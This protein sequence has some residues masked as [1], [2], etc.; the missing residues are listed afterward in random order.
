MQSEDQAKAS[1]G[2]RTALADPGF[3]KNVWYVAGWSSEFDGSGPFARRIADEP[4]AFFRDAQGTLVALADRCPHRWA[5]L[6]LGRVE[7][8]T[9]RCMYHGL[10]FA[11]SGQCVEVPEQD[12]IAPGL[13][14]RSYPVVERHRFAWVW[15]GDAARADPALIPVLT[16]LD[17]ADWRIDSGQID[18]QANCALINDN[19]VDLSH[20]SFVHEK[21]FGQVPAALRGARAK[22]IDRGVRMEGW[23]AGDG[24]GERLREQSSGDYS[25]LDFWGRLDYVVPGIFHSCNDPYPGGTAKASGGE[26]PDA[27]T[28]PLAQIHSIQAVTPLGPR[29]SRYFFAF[30][31]S[32][33]VYDDAAA[34]AQWR[35]IIEA[36][37]EDRI[38]IEAQQRVIDEDPG[39]RIAGI[40]ADRGPTL[41][42]GVLSKMMADERRAA[43]SPIGAD[44]ARAGDTL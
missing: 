6:S 37:E 33:G 43:A 20:A 13:C 14:A 7:G 1:R 38:I 41:F 32:P 27:G 5:P 25:H 9:L 3:L 19:L 35:I 44:A 31:Y 10:R 2:S 24:Y 21:T 12:S 40:A 39:D 17:Q 29:A 4:L 42:R 18:Y 26:A 36:F 28:P 11:A 23:V 30:C 8:D 22:T 34:A 16:P 15:M